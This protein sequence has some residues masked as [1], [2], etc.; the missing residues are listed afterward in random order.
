MAADN[1]PLTLPQ[2]LDLAGNSA[3]MG[4]GVVETQPD[5][6]PPI[7][8]TRTNVVVDA[9]AGTMKISEAQL[10]ILKTFFRTTL[11]QGALPFYFPDQ[12]L[13]NNPALMKFVSPPTWTVL[14]LDLYQV[15][16]ALLVLP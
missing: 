3:G 5:I 13:A 1:W 6:G 14:T 7:S 11:G 15:S 2:Y 8:R 10:A 12:T 4:N 16:L 9:I